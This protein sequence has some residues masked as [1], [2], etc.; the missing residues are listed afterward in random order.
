MAHNTINYGDFYYTV[1]D[2]DIA[3]VQIENIYEIM[4]N[5]VSVR[6]HLD[7]KP[8]EPAFNL[9]IEY[10]FTT[11]NDAKSYRAADEAMNKSLRTPATDELSAQDIH[12]DQQLQ[13]HLNTVAG[14][15]HL[16]YEKGDE[17]L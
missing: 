1:L 9:D 17:S 14:L 11:V 4:D 15:D 13:R 8:C 2:G 3:R 10:L 6:K 7:G 5:R 16:N 12:V